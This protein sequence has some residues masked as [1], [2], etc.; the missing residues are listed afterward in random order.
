MIYAFKDESH[1]FLCTVFHKETAL[2]ETLYSA[3]TEK[4]V[5]FLTEVNKGDGDYAIEVFEQNCSEIPNN[6]LYNLISEDKDVSEFNCYVSVFE[7]AGDKI[8]P[9][10]TEVMN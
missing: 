1:Y 4:C 6:D 7:I 9:K 8:Y 2:R 3:H 5:Q 10:S